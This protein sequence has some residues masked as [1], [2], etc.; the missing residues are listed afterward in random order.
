MFGHL[1]EPNMDVL[2]SNPQHR[3]AWAFRMTAANNAAFVAGS[4]A[5]PEGQPCSSMSEWWKVWCPVRVSG[6]QSVLSKKILP[7]DNKLL[8]SGGGGAS[9]F[10]QS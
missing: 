6:G 9:Y 7:A 2:D 1:I 10:I 5:G 4:T 8:N 3:F